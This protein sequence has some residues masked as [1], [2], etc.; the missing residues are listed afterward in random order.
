MECIPM[1]KEHSADAAHDVSNGRESRK[2]ESS[3][4]FLSSPTV[5]FLL[6]KLD[7]RGL[8]STPQIRKQS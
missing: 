2:I 6:V 5:I 1:M 3:A 7:I 8:S 4:F